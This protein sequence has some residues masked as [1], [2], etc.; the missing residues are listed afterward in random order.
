MAAIRR[1]L[2]PNFIHSD[3]EYI[4]EEPL[5]DIEYLPCEPDAAGLAVEPA[6]KTDLPTA[7]I[8]PEA[9]LVSVIIPCF[10][11]GRLI[12]SAIESIRR[13][14]LRGVEII[15]VEGGS[16]DQESRSIVANLK[17]DDI[18]VVMQD[19]PTLV[20]ANRN[21]GIAMA[22]SRYICCLDADDTL[23]PTYLEKAIYLLEAHG[24]DIVSTG[25]K[26]TGHKDGT[27]DVLETPTLRD[28]TEGNHI[29]TCAVFR[30]TLW[31]K[32]GGYFDTGKQQ[33][34]VAEDWDFWLRCV[35][36]GARARNITGEH[37]FNYTIHPQG[38]LSST[39][40]RSI[41]EQRRAILNR[42][43]EILTED[44]FAE[45]L[46]QA[47]RRLVRGPPGTGGIPLN[48]GRESADTA[49]GKR[50]LVAVPFLIVGGAERLLSMIVRHLVRLGWQVSIV[51]TL[52]QKGLE[53]AS[54]WFTALTSEVYIL[55]QFLKEWEY[56]SFIHYLVANRRF[57][58]LLVAGSRVFYELIPELRARFGEMAVIDLLFNTVGHTASHLEFK[59]DFDFAIGENPEVTSWLRANGWQQTQLKLIESGIDVTGFDVT[60]SPDLI[61]SLSLDNEELV[62]GFSGRLSDEKAPELFVQLAAALRDQ[63]QIRFVMTGAGPLKDSILSRIRKLPKDVRLDFMG[64]V[65]STQPYFA[66]YDVFVLPSRLDGRPIALLEALASGCAV[67]ASDVGG[68]PAVL[69]GTEAGILCRSGDLAGFEKAIRKLAGDKALLT[70]MKHAARQ[71]A[72]EKF[73][74]LDMCENYRTAIETAISIRRTGSARTTM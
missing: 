68:I 41:A 49:S 28:M 32:V 47:R 66:T 33:D 2:F 59:G 15:V 71:A 25:I 24:F 70:R 26:F 43:R 48:A 54:G 45:S 73:S 22:R 3:I 19:N 74:E 6:M 11:Y 56:T 8:Q 35:A 4:P 21:T 39:D 69:S 23:D 42:N 13:Q 67:V 1:R 63:R 46:R 38:S 53:D 37:L 16:T 31:E 57:D 40:V 50:L 9:P 7:G 62:V 61:Q 17:G 10:N 12:G 5:P 27:V 36:A 44:R 65:P 64:M 55:P 34:H 20:G 60:R 18:R 51:S 52:P 58:A 72:V 30:R 14:T 29:T